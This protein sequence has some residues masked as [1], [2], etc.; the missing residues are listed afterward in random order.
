MAQ[1]V[2]ALE[3]EGLLPANKRWDDL[4]AA[5]HFQ[6]RSSFFVGGPPRDVE[7]H[8]RNHALMMGC[9]LTNFARN[10]RAKKTDLRSK[11]SPRGLRIGAPITRF[12]GD[13]FRGVGARGGLSVEQVEQ[14]LSK[15]A[16]RAKWWMDGRSTPSAQESITT[17]KAPHDLEEQHLEGGDGSCKPATLVL[18]LAMALEAEIPEAT[19]NYFTV[20]RTTW[21]ALRDLWD[22]NATYF[23][24]VFGELEV[25]RDKSRGPSLVTF[26]LM[27]ATGRNDWVALGRDLRLPLELSAQSVKK[28]LDRGVG[29]VATA[30]LEGLGIKI[31][32]LL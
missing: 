8:F 32:G 29:R 5:R 11:G 21:Q 15:G 26:I 22:D 7:A 24:K 25:L 18:H 3:A 16:D 31:D 13:L 27:A 17:G 4:D 19:F 6:P 10:R 20:Y 12:T 2:H 30:E 9:S 23:G 28:M 1:L 14:I